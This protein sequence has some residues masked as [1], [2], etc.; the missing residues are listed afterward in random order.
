MERDARQVEGRDLR[1]NGSAAYR[2]E[3]SMTAQMRKTILRV[4]SIRHGS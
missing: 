2:V 4:E 3:A 1:V